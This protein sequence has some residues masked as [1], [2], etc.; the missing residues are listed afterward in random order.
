MFLGMQ[1]DLIAYAAKTKEELKNLENI[2]FSEIVET[3]ENYVFD[4]ASY[5]LETDCI[6]KLKNEKHSENTQKANDAIDYGYVEFKNAKFE[7]N[8]K[9][10]NDLKSVRDLCIAL[11]QESYIWLSMDDKKLE[12]VI[13]TEDITQDDFIQIGLIVQTYKNDVWMNKYLT[14]KEQIEQA[15]TIEELNEIVIDYER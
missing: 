9:T 5:V 1:N 3:E 4:G 6:K 10:L 8:A 2:R 14:Y 15:R 11:E 12:L 13:N 7:T